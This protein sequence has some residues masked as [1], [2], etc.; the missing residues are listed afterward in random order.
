MDNF[1][2][3]QQLGEPPDPA[4]VTSLLQVNWDKVAGVFGDQQKTSQLQAFAKQRSAA[5][6]GKLFRKP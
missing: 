5:L 6:L 3:Q 2:T 4:T 1:A